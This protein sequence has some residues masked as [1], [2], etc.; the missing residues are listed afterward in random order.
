MKVKMDKHYKTI[1]GRTVI[2]LEIRTH[3]SAGKEVTYPVKGTII[4]QDKPLKTRYEI[5]SINGFIDVVNP[6]RECDLVEA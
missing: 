5:W 1:N 4:L 6:G 2:I 3:N